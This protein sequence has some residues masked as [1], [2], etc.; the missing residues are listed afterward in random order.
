MTSSFSLPGTKL[1][2]R[3]YIG[4]PEFNPPPGYKQ[5]EPPLLTVIH[6]HC[7]TLP[8]REGGTKNDISMIAPPLAPCHDATSQ[9]IMDPKLTV[10]GNGK[11]K[12]CQVFTN[13]LS[14]TSSPEA[15]FVNTMLISQPCWRLSH[16]IQVCGFH[17]TGSGLCRGGFTAMNH[18]SKS[19]RRGTP[20]SLVNCL[21]FSLYLS[22][23]QHCY[24]K[25]AYL[26]EFLG[27]SG[28][29]GEQGSKQWM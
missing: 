13:P 22:P 2:A 6:P 26:A 8:E 10:N 18:P 25:T 23:S 24:S 15:A 21:P 16:V 27:I 7:P 17:N 28:E 12:M 20:I 5:E 1:N 29:Y 3:Q 19:R 11:P 4:P 14:S 9:L